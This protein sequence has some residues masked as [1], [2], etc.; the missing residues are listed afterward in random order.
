MFVQ[1][2]HAAVAPDDR[3]VARSLPGEADS[4]VLVVDRQGAAV[5]VDGRAQVAHPAIGMQEGMEVLV[6]GQVLRQI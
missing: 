3:E 5:A 4:L 1:R 6:V 2:L